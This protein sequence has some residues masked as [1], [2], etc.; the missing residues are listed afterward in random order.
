VPH[1]I[2]NRSDP[3][4]DANRDTPANRLTR[5]AVTGSYDTY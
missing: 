1:A 3:A 2:A 5:T 4:A